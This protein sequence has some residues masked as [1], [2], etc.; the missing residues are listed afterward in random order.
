MNNINVVQLCLIV[1][2]ASSFFVNCD[3]QCNCAD[4]A[5]IRQLLQQEM[6]ERKLEMSKLRSELQTKVNGAELIE[7]DSVKDTHIHIRVERLEERFDEFVNASNV[8][9]KAETDDDDDKAKLT[10]QKTRD[11]ESRVRK[12]IK[13]EK[14]ERL[15]F[16]ASVQN[17]TENVNRNISLFM[18][19]TDAFVK[20][21]ISKWS[22]HY[23]QFGKNYSQE[24]SEL[25]RSV[26]DK[27]QNQ[28]TATEASVNYINDTVDELKQNLS[29][30]LDSIMVN[31]NDNINDK[32]LKTES[33][34]QEMQANVTDV[35]KHVENESV[36]I[37][38]LEANV[39]DLDIVVEN[40]K[41]T[42]SELKEQL[43]EHIKTSDKRFSIVGKEIGTCHSYGGQWTLHGKQCY[44]FETDLTTWFNAKKKCEISGGDLLKIKSKEEN[45]F[46]ANH[47]KKIQR[48]FWIGI[49]DTQ[50]EN[51][52][53]WS[54][55]NGNQRPSDFF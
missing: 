14:A 27:L 8:E 7:T 54:S 51:N 19:T 44:R 31:V 42:V 12:A 2:I 22:V 23:N 48:S 30:R 47:I 11:F 10:T 52:W 35:R 45:D 20:D 1:I 37:N 15:K 26:E 49:H 18:K 50:E 21:Q 32:I 25:T 40:L 4:L 6:F 33:V 39:G 41:N 9:Q 5:F 29:R 16:I 3:G 24:F 17:E 36:A 28:A 13:H 46:I 43:K 38:S 53:Q 34:L 55:S